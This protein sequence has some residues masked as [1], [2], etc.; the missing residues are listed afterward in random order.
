MIAQQHTAYI[1]LGANL[2]NRL[3]TI[4]AAVNALRKL[5]HTTVTKTSAVYVTAP[6]DADGD[7]YLNAVAEIGTLLTP[8]ELLAGLQAIEQQFGRVRSYL[9]AQRTLDCDLLLYD[10]QVI[11]AP[12]LQVPHPRMHLRAFVLVPLAEIAPDMTIPDQGTVQTLLNALADQKVK[13][14]VDLI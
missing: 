1:G 11:D 3:E 8:A 13:K 10:Q 7:D 2:G 12:D 5:P 4:S 14:S 6:V 9:N